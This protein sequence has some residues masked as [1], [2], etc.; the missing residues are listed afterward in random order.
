MD[1]KKCKKCGQVKSLG[2]FYSHKTTR[3]RLKHECKLCSL[4][5]SKEYDKG[6]SEVRSKR[7]KERYLVNREKNLEYNKTR[8]PRR[9]LAAALKHHYKMSLEEWDAMMELQGGVCA[10]CGG[11][12]K[13]NRK[14]LD[15]DHDPLTSKIRGLLCGPCNR[16][17]AQGRNNPT[18]LRACADYLERT[19]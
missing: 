15:V 19:I 11:G 13:P 16:T 10:I 4:A 2:E 6:R 7:A 1:T 18:I 12:P 14:R 17:I 9:R 5:Y 8:D 3:D